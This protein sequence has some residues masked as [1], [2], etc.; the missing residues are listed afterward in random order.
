MAKCLGFGLAVAGVDRERLAAE[1]FLMQ[2]AWL[3]AAVSAFHLAKMQNI[4]FVNGIPNL[5]HFKLK[6]IVNSKFRIENF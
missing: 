3:S 6:I 2:P 5:R 1:L 4:V